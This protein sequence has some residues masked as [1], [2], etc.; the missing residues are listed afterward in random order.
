MQ[1]RGPEFA[2]LEALQMLSGHSDLL[3]LPGLRGEK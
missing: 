2:C 3:I 1:A